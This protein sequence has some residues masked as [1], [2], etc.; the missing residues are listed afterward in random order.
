[1]LQCVL[2]PDAHIAIASAFLHDTLEDTNLHYSNIMD[3]NSDVAK[4]VLEVT[5]DQQIQKRKQKENQ[6]NNSSKKS[7]AARM[8]KTAD[9]IDN[10][11]DF[12]N[13]ISG[14]PL[15]AIMCF[16]LKVIDQMRCPEIELLTQEFDKLFNN[17]VPK[18]TN[19]DHYVQQYLNSKQ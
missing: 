7:I 3:I 8:V 12:S 18:D 19:I 5:D 6:I 13:Q 9:K 2:Y 15:L 16:S 11:T 1:M 4:V 17:I 14:E 10:C